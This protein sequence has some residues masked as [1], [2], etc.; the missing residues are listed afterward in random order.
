M[1][2][3]VPENLHYQVQVG[4]YKNEIL[5]QIF[6]G[7]TPVY[8]TNTSAGTSYAIGMFEK[9][10]DATQAK[11]YVKSIGLNDAFVIAYYNKK[12]ISTEEAQKLENK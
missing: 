7:L 1:D 4:V 5:Y 6:K 2:A 9:L 8:G 11:E 10:N 12:R 3:A